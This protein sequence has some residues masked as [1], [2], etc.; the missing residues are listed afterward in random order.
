MIY[1]K[2]AVVL[3]DKIVIAIGDAV[4]VRHKIWV[5]GSHK[6]P[7]RD[8]GIGV[9]QGYVTNILDHKIELNHTDTISFLDIEGINKI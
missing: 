4:T 9:S 7:K 2:K 3:S 8:G 5:G 1:Y 6:Q